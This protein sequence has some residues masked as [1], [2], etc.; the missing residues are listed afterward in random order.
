MG[1]QFKS[2]RVFSLYLRLLKGE[3]INKQNYVLEEKVTPRTFERDIQTIRNCLSDAF[4]FDEI[5]YDSKKDGYYLRGG[6]KPKGLSLIEGFFLLHALQYHGA[7]REDEAAGLRNSVLAQ[8]SKPD[9]D[10]LQD[11]TPDMSQYCPPSHKQAIMKMVQDLLLMIRERRNIKVQYP[12]NVEEDGL[13]VSPLEIVCGGQ[14]FFLIAAVAHSVEEKCVLLDISMIRA[15]VPTQEYFIV[16]D[17]LQA[18]WKE[19]RET[20]YQQNAHKKQ[21]R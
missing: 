10:I 18:V 14:A 15:F 17:S 13:V 1:K 3:V 2:D 8:L 21:R 20:F 12:S 9:Q 16:N 5:L 11:I 4:L 6:D 7:L 19:A